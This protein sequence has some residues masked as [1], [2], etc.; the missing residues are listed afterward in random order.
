MMVLR[1]VRCQRGSATLEF[2]LTAPL[3]L[4]VLF[5]IGDF[6]VAMTKQEVLTNAA[7]EG[8]RYGIVLQT[9][10]RTTSQ[11]QTVVENY[12]TSA[13][14]TSGYTVTIPAACANTGDNL[15]VSV[16]Y[17]Y[18]IP[19][20]SSLICPTCLIHAGSTFPSSITLQATTVMKCE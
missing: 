3:L 14:I 13:H 15:S 4:A 12:L 5:G 16:S 1:K 18:T 7:R 9:P 17:P 19:V 2:A 6:G 8:A 20:L 11:I 10:R